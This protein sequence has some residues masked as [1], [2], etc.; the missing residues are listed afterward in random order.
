MGF[1]PAAA[2]QLSHKGQTHI[3]TL[4]L[5]SD[6]PQPDHWELSA[7]HFNW[8]EFFDGQPSPRELFLVFG[9]GC[10]HLTTGINKSCLLHPSSTLEY[11]R[12]PYKW[13]MDTCSSH[14]CLFSRPVLRQRWASFSFSFFTGWSVSISQTSRCPLAQPNIRHLLSS[15][16]THSSHRCPTSSAGH[17]ECSCCSPPAWPARNAFS[18]HSPMPHFKPC[19]LVWLHLTLP[20]LCWP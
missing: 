6:L 12:P 10:L 14:W 17:S 11:P 18:Q 16:T 5:R 3:L 13:W 2:M 8:Q 9:D 7:G 4:C 20:H 1:S 15:L 19:R